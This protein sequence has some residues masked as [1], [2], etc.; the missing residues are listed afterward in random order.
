MP[1]S[2]PN[3]ESLRARTKQRGFREPLEGESEADYRT[4]FADF[5]V[6]VDIVESSEIRSG[7]GWDEQDPSELV[8]H[9]L[10]SR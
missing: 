1:M 10:F 4:S 8:G 5:M 9:L 2:F 7:K 3:M 6:K